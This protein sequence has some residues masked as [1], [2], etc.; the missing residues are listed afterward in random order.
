MASIDGINRRDV[1]DAL[2]RRTFTGDV[3]HQAHVSCEVRD[4]GV[5]GG[6]HG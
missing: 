3:E 4:V 1:E 5:V 2:L 6:E